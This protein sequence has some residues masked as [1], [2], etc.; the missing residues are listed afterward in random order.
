M[1]SSRGTSP[2]PSISAAARSPTPASRTS[3]SASS[4]RPALTSPASRSAVATGRVALT[5]Y[6]EEVASFGGKDLTSAGGRDVFA[7]ELADADL[8]TL[9]ARA[10]G[11]AAFYQSGQAIAYDPGGNMLLA[12]YFAGTIDFGGGPLTSAGNVDVFV[13]KFAP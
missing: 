11:D 2:A 4:I 12:G 13:A 5:G 8:A 7:V 1:S 10:F 9:T 6:F 3:S